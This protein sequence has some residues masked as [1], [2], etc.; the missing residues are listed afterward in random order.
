MKNKKILLVGAEPDKMPRLKLVYKSLRSLGYD[1]KVFAPFARKGNSIMRYLANMTKLFFERADIYHF[2]N[3]PD[4][5]GLPLLFKR[6]TLIYDV[7]S[8][9]KEEVY[10][11]TNNKFIAKIAGIIEH[12][13]CIKAN[14]VIAA[15]PLLW[16][17]ALDFG[18]YDVWTIP[19]FPYEEMDLTGW[20]DLIDVS[21]PTVLYFGK[22]SKVEGSEVLGDIIIEA[23]NMDN[24]QHQIRFIIAGDGP[25][26]ENLEK[27]LIKANVQDK[28]NFLGWIPHEEIGKWIKAVDLCIMPREESGTSNWIHPDSVW[29]VNEALNIGTPVLATRI[30][31]FNEN[32]LN[33]FTVYPLS[34]TDNRGFA[35]QILLKARAS[36]LLGKTSPNPRDWKLCR[37]DLSELYEEL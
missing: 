16:E 33:S 36:K 4:V 11:T 37:D 8:P 24:R 30:G 1:V 26:R 19:N 13:F 28:V 9:W 5:I 18:S 15:N 2:F 3:I 32:Q 21:E 10:D 35:I 12:I 14:H 7:R 31:G 20:E 6:G 17:R 25:E 27:K 34:L 22:I 23:V 29:K